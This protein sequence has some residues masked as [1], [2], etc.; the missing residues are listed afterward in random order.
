MFV[1]VT[2]IIVVNS[3]GVSLL[4]HWT[5]QH[6][7]VHNWQTFHVYAEETSY[8]IPLGREGESCTIRFLYSDF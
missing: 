1:L 7:Q 3:S 6:F 2:D 8:L 5:T 4:C